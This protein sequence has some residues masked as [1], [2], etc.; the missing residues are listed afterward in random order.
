VC[1]VTTNNGRLL[2]GVCYRP[3]DALQDQDKL[4]YN[5]IENVG[6]KTVVLMGDFNYAGLNWGTSERIDRSHPFIESL[7]NKFLIQCVEEPTRN[8]NFLDLVIASEE[9]LVVNLKVLEPFCNSDHQSIS[10]SINSSIPV[11]TKSIP[12]F[13][14][15]RG[16]YE[17][18]RENMRASGWDKIEWGVNV[19]QVWAKLKCKLLDYRDKFIGVKKKNKSKCKWATRKVTGLRKAKKK[20][21]WNFK[22][23]G[24]N[25]VLYEVYKNKLNKSVSENKRAKKSFETR[26]ANNVKNNP[27]EFYAYANS[28]SRTNKQVGPLKNQQGELIKGDTETANYLNNYYSSVFTEEN[29]VNIPTPTQIFEGSNSDRLTNI[30][31]TEDMV[32]K[33]LSGLNVNKSSGVDDIHA[34]LLYELRNELVKPLTFLFNLS[35]GSSSIPQDWRDA[36]VVSI[37]KKGSKDKAENYRPVSLTSVVGKLLETLIKENIVEHLEKHGLLKDSQHGFRSGRSCLTNLL[38]FFESVTSELDDGNCADIIYL[39]FS[40]AFDKVPHCRLLKKLEA[41]GIGGDCLSWIGSWLNNRRQRVHLSGVYSEWAEVLSGVPQGSVLGPVLFLVYINDIDLGLLSKL[42]KFADDSK[43]LKGIR[44]QADVIEIKQDLLKLEQWSENWQMQFNSQKCSVIHLGH[45]N[46]CSEYFLYGS[47]LKPSEQERDLGVIVDKSLKFSEQCNVVASKANSQLGMIKR[48][49]ISRDKSIITKLYKALVRPKLEYCVQAWRPFLKKDIRKLEQVQHRATKMIHECRG[50]GYE[51]RLKITGLTS[52]EDRRA[53]GDLI[54]VYKTMT[55]KNKTDPSVFFKL[56]GINRTRG[57]SLK[58]EKVRSRLE[59]RR[60]FF[61]Q[62]V[63]NN[64]NALPQ[65]VVES[66]SVNTFKNR[67]DKYRA[68]YK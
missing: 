66:T 52:L 54:E 30:L 27:K 2:I 10:F 40:K 59:I 24:K 37:F 56:Q 58:L 61:S 28:K 63:I 34:K 46:P 9:N 20:A 4:L 19:D 3:P 42:G 26:L 38:D 57:H 64:W 15:F 12:V 41:H 51:D 36:N 22:Q 39:D 49:I 7:D 1:S 6:D 48:T 67:Y 18:I 23:S 50:L 47:E 68:S 44:S 35:L 25:P 43:L 29:L 8:N 55:G 13:N 32:F 11:K 33:K 31:V 65:E 21:W 45:N 14:Y 17:K 53:R 16:D 62:R 5:F 60:N